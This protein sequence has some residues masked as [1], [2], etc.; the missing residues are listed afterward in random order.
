M[1]WAKPDYGQVYAER[2]AAVEV[3]REKPGSLSGLNEYYS[4]RWAEFISNWAMTYDPRKIPLGE[5]PIMPFVLFPRQVEFVNWVYARFMARER[6]LVEKSRDMGV[7]WLACWCAICIWKFFPHSNTGFGS[8]KKE[9]VDNGEDDPDSLFWKIRKGIELLPKEFIPAGFG[10]GNKW[11]LVVNPENG[12]TIKGEIGDSIGMGGRC[13]AYFV[14]EADALEH[15]LLA[16]ASLSATTDCRIDL[17]TTNQVGSVFYNNRRSLPEH[18]VFIFDWT[19][20]PRKRLNPELAPGEEPWYLKQKRELQATTIASQIDR[21]PAGAIG[22]TYLTVSLIEDAEQRPV[23]QVEQAPTVPWLIGVD[24]SGMGN[25][26][27]VV[28]KRRGRI[29]V[30]PTTARMMDGVRLAFLVEQEVEAL[31]KIGPVGLIAVEQD[32]PGG[33]FADQLKQGKFREIVK[34]VHT[35]RKLSDGRHFNLRAWL[36]AQAKEYLEDSA[37]VLPKDPTFKAQ[38]TALLWESR[39]GLLLIESKDDYRKRLS[40]ATSRVGKMAGR[41]PDR[42]DAFILTFVPTMAKPITQAQTK[43]FAG[44]RSWRPLD[45]VIGY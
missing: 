13:V 34:A 18:Q 30:P 27:T 3:L 37:P 42:W 26:E 31:L 8:R 1:N 23:S 25:D 40:G 33:S 28:W 24:A 7:S 36:H 11:A 9:S 41:S 19:D 22:N 44:Q 29:S 16:E 43:L 32:G 12:S 14:D 21:N 15:Q 45:R 38:A 20:D 2:A 35:G 4:T 39:G 10:E 6:G 17:S 5:Q